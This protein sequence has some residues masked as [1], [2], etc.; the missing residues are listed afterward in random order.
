MYISL[1]LNIPSSEK[2]KVLVFRDSTTGL[3]F[4]SKNTLEN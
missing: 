1:D 3:N 4:I 2:L